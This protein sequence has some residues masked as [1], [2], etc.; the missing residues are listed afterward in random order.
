MFI[1]DTLAPYEELDRKGIQYT[2]CRDYDHISRYRSLRQV[3][4]CPEDTEDRFMALEV[5]NKI[6]E[7]NVDFLYHEVEPDEED[8]LDVIA[9]KNLGSASY[10]W[11]IAY[12]NG[13]EDGYTARPGQ[14]VKIPK[15]ISS[16]MTSGNIMQSVPA[17]QLNLGYED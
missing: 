12:F 6:T 7:S 8:R 14:V 2:V 11:V 4:H 17:L 9:Y 10:A 5:P 3:V 13:I 15:T 16:L 1:L